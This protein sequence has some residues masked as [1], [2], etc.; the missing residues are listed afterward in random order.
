[1]FEGDT[2]VS[3]KFEYKI[4]AETKAVANEGGVDLGSW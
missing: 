1:M 4:R 2:T 3:L